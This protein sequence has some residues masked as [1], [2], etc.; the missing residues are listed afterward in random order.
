MLNVSIFVFQISRDYGFHPAL[1][2][3][4]IGKRL[5]QDKDTL[6]NY[7]VRNHDDSAFLFIRSAQTAQLSREQERKEK[8]D[9]RIDGIQ[10]I[11]LIKKEQLVY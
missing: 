8:E 6:Y 10:T 3:W 11:F 2:R 7:G 5:A 9:R 1:Q 4:V